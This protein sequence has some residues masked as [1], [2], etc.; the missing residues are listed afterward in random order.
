MKLAEIDRELE[1]INPTW[2]DYK[3]GS[4]SNSFA[5]LS[6]YLILRSLALNLLLAN[7]FYVHVVFCS[8]DLI[9]FFSYYVDQREKVKEGSV[10][11]TYLTD[12]WNAMVWRED[13]AWMTGCRL[14]GQ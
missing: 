2:Q 5:L 4:L 3:F 9:V 12:G 13:I 14:L 10:F 6:F 8:S 1:S 11:K 7:Q